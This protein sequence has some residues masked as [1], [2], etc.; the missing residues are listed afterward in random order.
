MISKLDCVRIGRTSNSSFAASGGGKALPDRADSASNGADPSA[1]RPMPDPADSLHRTMESAADPARVATDI[2]TLAATPRGW[3]HPLEMQRAQTY[4]S[5]QLTA[6]GW[7]VSPKPFERRWVLG[8]SDAGGR[9]SFLSRLRLFPRLAGT[10]LLAE[11][12]G[13]PQGRRVLVVAHLDTVACS[14][15]ADD[16]ASG[17]AALLE[18]ARL[19]ATLDEPVAVTLAVVDMEER[20]KVGSGA[21]ARDRAFRRNLDLVL[22]LESVGTFTDVPHT[23]QMGGLGLIFRDL[24]RRVK[25]G[26]HRGDFL[27][28]VCRKS[29][30]EA[31]DGLTAAGAALTDPLPV[32][33]ARDPRPDGWRG[34]LITWLLPLLAHLDRS[35]HAPFWSRGVPAVLLTTTASFRNPHYH[36]AGDEPDTVDHH[37]VTSVA[38]ALADAIAARFGTHNS[39]AAVVSGGHTPS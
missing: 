34:R 13:A 27:L 14:P 6:A 24:D 32:L 30:M 33:H 20:A 3:H 2:A 17:V 22:C 9:P 36:L 25:A 15:G 23:Q 37:R 11:L 18:T 19:L 8:V 38:I 31:A 21:L 29:S 35:D 1:E 5:E 16:N 26:R 28:A 12:P 10:N 4:V 39:P 7:R